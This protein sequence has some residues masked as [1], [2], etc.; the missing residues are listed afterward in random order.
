MSEE[1]QYRGVRAVTRGP[2]HHF[3]GYYDKSPW[4]ATGRHLLALET[5]FMDRPPAADDAAIIGVVDLAQGRRFR[6]LAETRAWNWQQG[7]MLQWVAL[8]ADRLIIHNDRIRDRFVSTVRDIDT[9]ESRT[10]PR[11]IYALTRDGSRALSVNFAR[12]HRLRPGYGYAGA[13]DPRADD[14]HPVDD[15]VYLMDLSTGEHRLVMSLA[16]I[17]AF[18]RDATMEGG[19]HWFNHLLVSP[20]NGRFIFLHRWQRKEGGRYTRM[21]TANL[22][23]SGLWCAPADEMVS[24]FDWCGSD[25]ILAWARRRDIGERYYLFTDR[26]EEFEVV[27]EGVLTEDGHGSYSP[28]GRWLLT[29]TYPDRERMRRL[30]LYHSADKRRVD[31]GRFFSPAALELEIRCDLHP[32]WSRDGRQVCIDSAHE[33]ARQVYVVDAAPIT[34]RGQLGRL[35]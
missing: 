15:G 28:D 29:D 26:S 34:C 16:Q 8:A 25:R 23:G 2:K 13:P 33:G 35:D 24:H 9:G 20:D 17:A 4:D 22:D 11:P 32:R 27:G 30:I 18:R 6:P 7:S 5:A 3:F 19:H 14:P 31:I 1:Q 12:L 10:L 21:F